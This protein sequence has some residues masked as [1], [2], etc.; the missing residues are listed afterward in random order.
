MYIDIYLI[1]KLRPSTALLIVVSAVLEIE[2]YLSAI[3]TT[4]RP[5]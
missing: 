5:I 3:I 4:Y 1:T 2:T